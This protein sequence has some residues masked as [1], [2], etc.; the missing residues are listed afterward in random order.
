MPPPTTEVVISI[1][2]CPDMDSKID[3]GTDKE[4]VHMVQQQSPE[5]QYHLN[6]RACGGVHCFKNG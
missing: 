2:V 5:C 1:H 6:Q 4:R 3:V